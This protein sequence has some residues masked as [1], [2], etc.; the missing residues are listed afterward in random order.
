[1]TA[2]NP[3]LSLVGRVLLSAIFILGGYNKL[4]NPAGTIG[5]MKSALIPIPSP[6]LMVWGV[7]A[8]E[9]LGGLAILFGVLSR[10]AAFLLAGFTLV[11]A[12][13][14]HWKPGDQMQHIMFMK[15]L[16]IAGG[17]MLLAANGPGRWGRG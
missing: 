14:F 6:E 4:M 17:L 8:L 2:L 11:A 16:A 3:L 9:L 10:S 13:L 15:N 1:M 5:Y 7:I 12:V